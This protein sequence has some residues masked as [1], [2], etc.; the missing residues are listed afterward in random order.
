MLHRLSR[1]GV[2]VSEPGIANPRLTLPTLCPQIVFNFSNF[3]WNFLLYTTTPR[4]A[5]AAAKGDTAGASQITSQVGAA[6][7]H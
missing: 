3:I 7:Q 4:I 5:A 2:S 1:Q 6:G